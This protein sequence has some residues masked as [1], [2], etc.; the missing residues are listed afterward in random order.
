[1]G[2]CLAALNSSYPIAGR[3]AM[4]QL[5]LRL[6]QC[7]KRPCPTHPPIRS[8]R[9]NTGPRPCR[10]CRSDAMVGHQKRVRSR[11]HRASLCYDG[12]SRNRQNHD[13]ADHCQ[14]HEL[15]W[16]RWSGWPRRP[17]LAVSANTAPQ[18]W[19]AA[20]STSS[21]WTRPQ[22]QAS[23]TCAKSSIRC[24]TACDRPVQSLYHRRRA[25]A[26]RAPSRSEDARRTARTCQ[27]HLRHDRNPQGSR[28]RPVTMPAV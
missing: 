21:K 24:I 26:Q 8:L 12:H 5:G 27:I 2:P 25:H 9:A 23:T 16:H 22:T 14:R 6:H 28:D 7:G 4:G 11:P 18:S 15:Y 19:K 3:G 20:M 10:P 1:M 13:R 17:S